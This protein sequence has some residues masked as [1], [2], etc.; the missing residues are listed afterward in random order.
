MSPP[1]PSSPR[2]VPRL[3]ADVRG[4]ALLVGALLG[5]LAWVMS[6]QPERTHFQSVMAVL[7]VFAGGASFVLH[8][9]HAEES[10]GRRNRRDTFVRI[11]TWVC[12]LGAAV[13]GAIHLLELLA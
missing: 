13:I 10:G 3:L 4:R 8:A 9:L 12:L 5:V 1:R 7:M 2:R 11:R 6:T